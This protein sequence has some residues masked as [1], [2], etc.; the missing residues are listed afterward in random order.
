MTSEQLFASTGITSAHC[1]AVR[2]LGKWLEPRLEEFLE[3]FYAR[4]RPMPEFDAF[5]SDPNDLARVRSAQRTAWS[6]FFAA[7][8]DEAYVER[9]RAIGRTHANA[10]VEIAVYL[11]AMHFAWSWFVARIQERGMPHSEGETSV[12]ALTKLLNLDSLIVSAA[13]SDRTTQIIQER[14]TALLQETLQSQEAL[15]VRAERRLETS[16]TCYRSLVTE[17][18]DGVVMSD[19]TGTIIASN[20]AGE[21][22]LGLN[23]G[24]L[25]QRS[26]REGWTVMRED[27]T[28]LPVEEYPMQRAW[29]SGEGV[30]GDTF[31]VLRP[32]GSTAWIA[33]D[34]I[35]LTHPG[36]ARPYAVLTTF[37]DVTEIRRLEA[38]LRQ[39]QRM[40][41]V[42]QLAGG[43]AHDFNNLLTGIL[44]FAQFVRRSLDADDPRSDDMDQ[45]IQAGHR[46]ASLTNQLLAFSRRQPLRPT[47]FDM[48]QVVREFVPMLRRLIGE[49]IE[50]VF[51]A[52]PAPALVH[53][54][55]GQI[56]QVIMNL[57]VNA[58]DAILDRGRIAISTCTVAPA[59]PGEASQVRL[60]VRDTG[61]GMDAVT[62]D[63]LFEPF[64]TTKPAGKGTGLGLATVYGIVTQ[65][66]GTIAVESTPGVGTTFTLN[67]P[68]SESPVGTG[69]RRRPT[70]PGPVGSTT[71][72]LVVEDDASLREVVRRSLVD[73]GFTVL[74][75]KDGAEAAQ[76][77]EPGGPRV[78]LLISDVV[79]PN[80]NGPDCAAAVRARHE[81]CAVIFMTGYADAEIWERVRGDTDA[82]L[83]RKP[84]SLDDL[85]RTVRDALEAEVAP[86]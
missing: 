2:A 7:R 51:S 59:A 20:P 70:E 10:G 75:A 5:F 82:L 63:R 14:A 39:A 76:L 3:A 77:C 37:R 54:E 31:G 13:Y 67:F 78:D 30:T 60:V 61:D 58:R 80:M 66:L 8:V 84:F 44:G 11:A 50:L 83:L 35:P 12:A 16:E 71:T 26:V 53:A 24:D 49:N 33:V 46:A 57:T 15:R 68:L 74:T 38:E 45:I 29:S 79:M 22:I 4:L 56:E 9:Q 55:R 32:D 69:I 65:S 85:M 23:P 64:F 62:R 81:N 6:E 34:A 41:S 17:L 86:E 18:R 19:E 43:V 21:R 42:G 25:E 73:T 28:P 1:Q 52:S 72:A 27:G 40:E 47:T 36:Q 48:N